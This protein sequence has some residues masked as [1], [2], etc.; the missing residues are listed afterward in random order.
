MPSSVTALPSPT[1]LAFAVSPPARHSRVYRHPLRTG[2]SIS[3][4]PRFA[5]ATA[6]RVACPPGGSDR[7]PPRRRGLLLPSFRPVRPPPPRGLTQGEKCSFY[8][9]VVR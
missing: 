5:V 7:A 9:P 6:C 8:P 1:T 3:R 2:E 4:L